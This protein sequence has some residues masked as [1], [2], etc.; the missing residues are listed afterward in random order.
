MQLE[1][2]LGDRDHLSTS[3]EELLQ[4]V[5]SRYPGL[6]NNMLEDAEVGIISAN[7]GGMVDGG[8]V[9]LVRRTATDPRR[10]VVSS[11]TGVQL[12]LQASS[13]TADTQGVASGTA[14]FVWALPDKGPFP[15]LIGLRL[16]QAETTPPPLQDSLAVAGAA[17]GRRFPPMQVEIRAGS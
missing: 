6:A 1:L 15:Q 4:D 8:Y 9:Y 3:E 2:T 17:A 10:L 7:L 12:Q 16:L 5:L 11:P 14:P 13:A